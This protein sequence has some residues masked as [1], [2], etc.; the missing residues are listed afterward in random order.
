VELWRKLAIRDAERL[1]RSRLD[2]SAGQIA[3]SNISPDA[4]H[5]LLPLLPSGLGA[6]LRH[7]ELHLRELLRLPW[8]PSRQ[9][10]LRLLL[11]LR[12]GLAYALAIVSLGG[13]VLSPQL[14]LP[15]LAVVRRLGVI[16]QHAVELEDD[17]GQA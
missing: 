6:V 13:G 11:G 14:T 17:R 7:D 3:G 15:A 9:P 4:V 2:P 10:A 8:R 12:C 5:K 16:G 1:R